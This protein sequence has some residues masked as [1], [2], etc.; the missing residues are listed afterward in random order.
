MKL[1]SKNG[2]P[3]QLAPLLIVV[4]R[5]WPKQNATS[6]RLAVPNHGSVDSEKIGNK[7]IRTC[8]AAQ[9][10]MLVMTF[11]DAASFLHSVCFNTSSLTS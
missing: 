7:K 11:M 2:V 8:L 5:S 6:F 10:S 4:S 1:H 9:I 3:V